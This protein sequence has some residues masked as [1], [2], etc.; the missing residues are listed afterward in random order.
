MCILKLSEYKCGHVERVH[1][2]QHCSCP[3]LVGVYKAQDVLCPRNC[4]SPVSPVAFR[5]MLGMTADRS[6]VLG[7]LIGAAATCGRM[8][9]DHVTDILPWEKHEGRTTTQRK[10]WAVTRKESM[11]ST[12]SESTQSTHTNTPSK[13]I[14][15]FT[16]LHHQRA[17]SVSSVT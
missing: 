13:L 2:N 17:S 1:L 12:A 3:L 14:R 11:E 16:V 6:Q 8:G 5:S 10:Q 9:A 7:E 15:T 4:G